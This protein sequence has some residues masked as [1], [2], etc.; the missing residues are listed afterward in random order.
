MPSSLDLRAWFRGIMFLEF[1]VFLR[2]R[3]AAISVVK[4]MRTTTLCIYYQR[5]DMSSVLT[6]RLELLLRLISYRMWCYPCMNKAFLKT[7]LDFCLWHFLLEILS[8]RLQNNGLH[9][10][11]WALTKLSFTKLFWLA[12]DQSYFIL[13]PCDFLFILFWLM[14]WIYD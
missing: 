8:F 1:L 3:G 14:R 12:F 6:H 13:S 10:P 4:L 9:R 2:Y 7:C 11:H 5:L